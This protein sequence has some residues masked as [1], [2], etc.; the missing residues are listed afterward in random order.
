MEKKLFIAKW[1]FAI[2]V[3]LSE[4][5]YSDNLATILECEV[6]LLED[7]EEWLDKQNEREAFKKWLYEN[8]LEH[9]WNNC[10]V[11]VTNISKDIWWWVKD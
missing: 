11:F 3:E 6:D 5:I 10:K 8:E 7:F 9:I 4:P 2:A 1:Y